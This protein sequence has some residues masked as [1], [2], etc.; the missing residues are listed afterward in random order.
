MPTPKH[1][2][3][4]AHRRERIFA[5]G[6]AVLL[7][8]VGDFGTTAVGIRMMG[9]TEVHPVGRVVL[10]SFGVLGILGAKVLAVLGVLAAQRQV[11]SRGLTGPVTLAVVGLF[12][13][14]WN[15]LVILTLAPSP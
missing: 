9:A 6:A 12:L 2:R 14:V 10:A 15:S 11:N 8:V 5:W 7:F 13:T 3:A 4:P 1:H